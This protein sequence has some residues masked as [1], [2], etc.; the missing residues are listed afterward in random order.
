MRIA[1]GIFS[2]AYL[3]I[4]FDFIGGHEPSDLFVGSTILIIAFLCM[5]EAF[6][7]RGTELKSFELSETA[8]T[9]DGKTTYIADVRKPDG[10]SKIFRG[11]TAEEARE[12]AMKYIEKESK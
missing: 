10:T 2:L 11:Q 4:F 6:N 3:I 1:Y 9:L 12:K 7:I 5:A 8:V